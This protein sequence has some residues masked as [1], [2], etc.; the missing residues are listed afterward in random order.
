MALAAPWYVHPVRRTHW[1]WLRGADIGIAVLN[2][3]DGPGDQIEPSYQDAVSGSFRPRVLGYVD[4]AYGRRSVRDVFRDAERWREWYGVSGIFLDQVPTSALCGHWRI[5]WVR[6]LRRE[7]FSFVAAN[8]G[9]APEDVVLETAD[10]T[11]VCEVDWQSYQMLAPPERLLSHPPE[12]QWH[13]VHSVPV[14]APLDLNAQARA[15]GASWT[16]ATRG[17]LPNPWSAGWEGQ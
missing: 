17:V 16:W 13:L 3:Q 14:W 12:R 10:L 4:T 5:D 8:C 9:T 7:G 6:E 1:E 11:C 2:V 15:R